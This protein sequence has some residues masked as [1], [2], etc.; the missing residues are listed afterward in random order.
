M[1]KIE[2]PKTCP[3]CGGA[4]IDKKLDWEHSYWC[5]IGIRHA[6]MHRETM[7]IQAFYIVMGAILAVAAA[8]IMAS[9][10]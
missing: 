8:W 10:K 4:W 3:E 1:H 2:M 6:R 9:M 5:P 7:L